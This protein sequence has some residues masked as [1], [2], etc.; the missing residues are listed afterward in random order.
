MRR[1]RLVAPLVLPPRTGAVARRTGVPLLAVLVGLRLV[2]TSPAAHQPPER[3]GVP[4]CAA[5]RAIL[6]QTGACAQA[7]PAAR[8]AGGPTGPGLPAAQPAALGFSPERLARIDAVMQEY[9]DRGRI[10]GVVTL[11]ARGGRTVHLEAYGWRDRERRDP[12]R[13]DTIFRIASMTKAVTSVAAMMLVEEGRLALG[14]RVSEFVPAFKDVRVRVFPADDAAPTERIGTV[15][16]R[17]EITVR[18]LLAHTA[19]LGYG[20]GPAEGLYKQAGVYMWY[21]ADKTEPMGV[22]VERLAGL[23]LDAQPGEKWV[24]GFASDVLGHVAERA[25][26][27]TLDE[28]FRSRIL[29]P[30]GMT[31]THFFLPRE[32]ASRLAVVYSATKEGGIERAPEAGMVGQGAYVDGPRVCFSGGAGLLSTANDYARFLQMLANG[33]ALDG[34]RLLAPKTVELMTVNHVGSLYR[35]GQ[36]GFGLGFEVVEHLG[37]AGRF[38][39]VGD[40]GWGGAYYTQFWVDRE[41]GIVAVFMAQLLPSGG[42]DLQEKFRALVYQALVDVRPV[43]MPPSAPGGRRRDRL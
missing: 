15:P 23:P 27:M 35:E 16:A 38:G 34:I 18:D 25:S 32:K 9:V 13:P 31:D 40:A 17:R 5:G 29:G 39:S 14:S 36:A 8:A 28:F 7:L 42:L 24:Y 10:A 2:A 33:G 26:G 19:G 11:V 4:P 6:G 20:A 3:T 30:L 12:M 21:F 43:G 37:R 1:I 22:L 41:T